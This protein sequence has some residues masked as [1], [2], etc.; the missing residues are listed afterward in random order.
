MTVACVHGTHFA[1]FARQVPCFVPK[2]LMAELVALCA[3]KLADAALLRHLSAH[4]LHGM[5]DGR[6]PARY[7]P[8]ACSILPSVA[9][10]Q[11]A[12]LSRVAAA[13]TDA[14]I[15]RIRAANER[16]TAPFAAS[17]MRW[18][19]WLIL[20]AMLV[21]AVGPGRPI[22]LSSLKLAVSAFEHLP[23]NWSGALNW[24]D[25]R[26][27]V[28]IAAHTLVEGPWWVARYLG[29][30]LGFAGYWLTV[31]TA[32]RLLGFV[33]WNWLTCFV[34]PVMEETLKRMWPPMIV[35]GSI[36]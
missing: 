10:M 4:A 13:L 12:G 16:A 3:N 36:F 32:P 5:R 18:P 2:G 22:V 24:V 19:A 8:A 6:V 20:A 15:E 9:V 7:Q 11:A 33:R 29:A 31:V 23:D 1:L 34:S 14:H 28:H 35:I 25:P 26:N 17:P 30:N 21:V 27:E